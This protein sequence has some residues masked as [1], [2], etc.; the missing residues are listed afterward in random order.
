MLDYITIFKKFK[1]FDVQKFICN[2]VIER[3]D[4]L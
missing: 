3:Q 2:D 4:N 1:K